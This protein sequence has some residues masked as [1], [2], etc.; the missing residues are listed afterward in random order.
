MSDEDAQ[1]PI[2]DLSNTCQ[3]PTKSMKVRQ[4]PYC[5]QHTPFL[6]QVIPLVPNSQSQN[7][8][9]KARFNRSVIMEFVGG[10]LWDKQVIAGLP[11]R[12]VKRE[13]GR[14]V[15][16]VMGHPEEED[17]WV[18]IELRRNEKLGERD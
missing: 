12:E 8:E 4:R 11:G 9:I 15:K 18:V 16:V 3:S 13:R 14:M 6:P 17:R 5:I 10:S 2:K 1:R 7:P